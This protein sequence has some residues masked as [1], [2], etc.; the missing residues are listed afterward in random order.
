[1]KNFSRTVEAAA[2][3]NSNLAR[4]WASSYLSFQPQQFIPGRQ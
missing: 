2:E 4:S 1:V 3:Y